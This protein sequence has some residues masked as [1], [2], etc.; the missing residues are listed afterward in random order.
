[1]DQEDELRIIRRAYAKQITAA[2]GVADARVQ[3][4]FA[5]VRREAF[6]GPGP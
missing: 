2:V 5:A 1:M 3:D 4:A 6:L